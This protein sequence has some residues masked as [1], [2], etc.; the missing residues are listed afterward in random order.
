[1]LSK[2]KNPIIRGIVRISSLLLMIY[3]GLCIVLFFRQNAMVFYPISEVTMFPSVPYEDFAVQTEIGDTV[4]GW[5]IPSSEA[6]GTL[7]FFHGNAGNMSHRLYTAE[8]WQKLHFNFCIFD[9][10]GYG[11][12]SGKTSE[13]GCY[14]SADAVWKWLLNNKKIGPSEIILHGRS[15]GGAVAVELV[16]RVPVK[17]SALILEST[18]LSIPEMGESLYPFLPISLLATIAFNTE[19]KIGKLE[20]PLLIINSEADELVPY[21]HGRKLFELANEP[22]QFKRIG[23][24]HNYGFLLSEHDYV[25]AL[26]SFIESLQT[27]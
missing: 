2:I 19:D 14:Q 3:G 9:Y 23:G 7:L 26:K 1:M 25:A 6:K 21:S 15:L 8:L 5:F 13:E 17:P 16:G 20:I 11:R 18:F 27:S 22:K 12:S 10:P 4:T 24:S